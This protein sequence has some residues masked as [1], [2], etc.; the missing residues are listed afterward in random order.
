MNTPYTSVVIPVYNS[1]SSLKELVERL[2]ATLDQEE[3]GFELILIDDGSKDGS[4]KTL[5]A[6]KQQYPETLVAI[7]LVKNF[8]QHKAIVCGLNFSLGQ[9]VITMDDDLQHP[10]EEI[11]KL[12]QRQRETQ[13]DVVYGAY[14]K[15][16]H[17]AVRTAGSYMVRRSSKYFADNELGEG[18]SFRLF[19]RSVVDKIKNQ[20]QTFMFIDEVLHWFTSDIEMV[21]VEHHPRKAGKSSYNFFKLTFL[22][23]AVLVNYTAWPLR[24]M[25]YGGLALSIISFLIGVYFIVR[26]LL[27]DIQVEGF[28]AV[29][30]TVLF[31][32]S[33]ML[34]C[35]GIVG[36][37]LYK[38]Y[39]SQ[40][41]KP[42]YKVRKV[43]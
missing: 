27:F 32:T 13:C 15:K 34:I 21:E 8:G 24:L 2:H 18:S 31:S 10:P 41:G 25:T 28:T 33:L 20:Q 19:A 7:Q 29:I 16:Q 43:L 37:Y 35:F 3:G 5:Q 23:F 26:R 1:Q 38:I 9:V 4:W 14:K 22:Y 40:N 36:Q 42:P 39:Q 6:L 17:G 30:V 12:I 11:P